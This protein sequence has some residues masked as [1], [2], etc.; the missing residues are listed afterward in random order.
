MAPTLDSLD[1]VHI[2]VA[3]RAQ[4]EAWYARVLGLQ[5]LPECEPWLSAQGPLTLGNATATVHLALFERPVEKC[6]SV[7]A[8]RTTAAAFLAW[9]AH[10]SAILG[11]DVKAV[12]HHLAWSLYFSDPDGNPFEITS[13]EHQQIAGAL[14][15]AGADPL[16]R[17]EVTQPGAAP[18]VKP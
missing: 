4:S 17:E 3:N 14:G 9:R 1:H 15:A 10:L 13:Y 2:H 5:R 8:L 12:D 7:V 6:H 18:D 11:H 16:Q